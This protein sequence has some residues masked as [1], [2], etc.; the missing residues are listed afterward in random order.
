MPVTGV[1]DFLLVLVCP[2]HG[3]RSPALLD[4]LNERDNDLLLNDVELRRE[5]CVHGAVGRRLS[6]AVGVLG[7]VFARLV[8]VSFCAALAIRISRADAF[9]LWL[10]VAAVVKE[11][12]YFL[13]VAISR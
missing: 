9:G 8:L 7:V 4:A 2:E 5:V 6:G 3:G 1:T 10:W 11:V 12:V 13:Y